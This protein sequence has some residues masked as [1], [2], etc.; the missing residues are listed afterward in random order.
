MT[1]YISVA[2]SFLPCWVY[3]DFLAEP[4]SK[5]EEVFRARWVKRSLQQPSFQAT[6]QN[7]AVFSSNQPKQCLAK[8]PFQ[9]QPFRTFFHSASMNIDHIADRRVGGESTN[10]STSFLY[11]SLCGQTNIQTLDWRRSGKNRQVVGCHS[12]LSTKNHHVLSCTVKYCCGRQ[13][14]GSKGTS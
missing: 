14:R 11:T 9:N 5:P 13:S 4:H 12:A 10:N 3:T 7:R 2:D 1:I 8:R 6:S